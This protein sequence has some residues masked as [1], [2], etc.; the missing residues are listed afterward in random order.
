MRISHK[1]QERSPEPARLKEV[2]GKQDKG[3]NDALDWL[4]RLIQS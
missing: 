4:E 3:L 1:A 2:K